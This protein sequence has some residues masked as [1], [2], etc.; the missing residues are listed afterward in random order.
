[1]TTSLSPTEETQLLQ[2]IEMFELITQSQPNDYQS[3]DILKEAYFKLG[4]HKDVINTSKRIAQAYLQQGQLS[5]AILEYESILQLFPDDP[6]VLAALKEIE[7]KAASYNEPSASTD[8][9]FIV[10][11]AEPKSEK[12]PKTIEPI[13][14]QSGQVKTSEV[15]TTAQAVEVEPP[16]EISRPTELKDQKAKEVTIQKPL[17]E[18]AKP[19]EPQKPAQKRPRVL[20]ADNQIDDGKQQ[21]HKLFVENKLISEEDFNKHWYTPDIDQ[22]AKNIVEPFIKRLADNKLVPMEESLKLLCSKTRLCFLPL[23]KYDFDIEVAR[24]FQK[25]TCLQWCVLPFD[26]MSKSILVATA[27]PF[28]KQA[29]KELSDCTNYRI[30]WYIANPNSIITLL[31][32]SYRL[33]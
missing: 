21:M 27:N 8:T 14:S 6:D 23:E 18:V 25:D 28:N 31:K 29:A 22:P 15:A 32:K 1:M 11:P 3:L 7:Q 24:S 12:E 17:I 26:K 20:T 30:I 13:P 10:K 33:Q 16:Q 4:R 2:T 5:S 19:I 9:D